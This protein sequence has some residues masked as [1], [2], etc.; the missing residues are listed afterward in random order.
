[1]PVAPNLYAL[2]RRLDRYFWA[3]R[4]SE[5]VIFKEIFTAYFGNFERVAVIGGLV[6]DFARE[7]RAGF[8]SDIDLVIDAPEGIVAGLARSLN[9]TPNRY[10]GY[11]VRSSVWQIDFWALETTWAA[12]NAG[13]NV[14]R[15]QDV[16]RCTFFD[17]DAIA[18]DLKSQRLIC[19]VD[20]LNRI[21]S[22]RIDVNLRMTPSPEGNLLRAVRRMVLWQLDPGPALR[23]FIDESLE[24]KTF[25]AIKVKERERYKNPVT[26]AW[27]SVEVAKRELLDNSQRLKLNSQ[28]RLPLTLG[29]RTPARDVCTA[30]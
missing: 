29:A 28:L 3:N 9:A 4:S 27:D 15:L 12:R 19:S 16:I 17:W 5:M 7:G 23:A 24:P 22:R 21:S 20:Y 6:R 11:G 13:I 26:A 25:H 2:K 18:Y 10:G 30:G 1:M 8:R 14:E